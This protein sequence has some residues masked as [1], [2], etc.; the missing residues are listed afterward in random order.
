MTLDGLAEIIQR[1]FVAVGKEFMAVRKEFGTEFEV[2]RYEM[3]EENKK[4]EER[5]EKKMAERFNLVLDGQ[6][7][8]MKKL[9]DLETEKTMGAEAGRRQEDKLEDHE[10]RIETVEGKL[11][12]APTVS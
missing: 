5:I 7:E 1:E 4:L 6:D 3:K 9:E 2:I 11:N 12:I 10:E 8:I